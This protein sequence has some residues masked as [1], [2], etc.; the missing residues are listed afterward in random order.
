MNIAAYLKEH[1]L[2]TDGA[3]GTY[4][5]KKYKDEQIFVE[6]AN[7]EAPERVKEIHLDYIAAGAKLIRT[8]TFATN[9]MFFDT[10]E[11]V[12]E[13]IKEGYH[14]AEKAVA[15]SGSEVFIAADLGPI[16]DSGEEAYEDVLAEYKTI[17]DTFFACGARIF[18]FETLSDFAYVSPLAAYIKE[19]GDTFVIVQFSFDK[20]GYT[21]SGI[22]VKRVIELAA[23]DDAIDAYGFNCGVEAAHL[24][25]LLKDAEFPNEKYLTALP[26]AGYP[27]VLRGKTVYSSNERYFVEMQKKIAALGVDILGG[28]CGTEPSYIEKLEQALEEKVNVDPGILTSLGATEWEYVEEGGILT[29]LW[30]ISGAY[31][32]GITFSLLNMPVRQELIEVC[33]LLDLN[34]Y[35]LW[36]GDCVLVAANH[37][38]DMARGLAEQGIRASVIGKVEKGIARKMTGVGGTGYLERPQPDELYKLTEEV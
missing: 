22:S 11:E 3:M 2:I 21:K 6:R 16:Y 38:E 30:N 10:M 28:C 8:N 4:Y 27:V 13:N 32:Q 24:Y 19:K 36:C 5:Q 29:A 34:P 14:I 15:E 33:E 17:C 12:T 9:T 35:R 18:L 23:G 31:G 37:G 7:T 26:N 20:S 1:R 25:Q